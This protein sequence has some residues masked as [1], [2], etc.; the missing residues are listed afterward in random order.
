M[1]FKKMA[2]ATAAVSMLLV[3]ALPAHAAGAPVYVESLQ[4]AVYI[5]AILTSGDTF[6]SYTFPGVPDGS[7]AVLA[8]EN[9]RILTN[10][11]LSYSTTSAALQR[12]N[13]TAQGS[14]ISQIDYNLKTRSVSTVKEFLTSV[15]HY[16]YATKKFGKTPV[17]PAGATATDSYGTPLHSTFLARFC[18]SSLAPAGRL[19]YKLGKTTY[20]ITESVFLTGEETGDEGR[21]F[22]VNSKGQM[23]HI[24][25]FGLAAWET[26]NVVPTSSKVT[27][28]IGNE[29]N[30]ATNSQVSMYVGTKTTKGTWYEKAGFTNGARYILNFGGQATEAGFRSTYPKGQE[31]DVQFREVQ[32]EANGVDQNY[33]ASTVGT[34]LARVEDGSF[35]P[36]HPNDYYFITTESNKDVNATKVDPA[37]PLQPRDGGALWR[38]RFKDV[39]NPLAGAT[40]TMLLNG[41]EAP[42]LNKPD[43]LEVDAYGNILIQEDPG[44][45]PIRT[46]IFAYRISDG[47]IATLAQFKKEYFEPGQANFITQD[48]ETSGIF[49]ATKWL[50]KSATDTN[51]YYVFVAQV[52]ANVL[53]A[54]PDLVDQAAKDAA[55][56]AIEGGQMYIMTVKDWSSVYTG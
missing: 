7:G 29:D 32:T 19:A 22:V 43:N 56:K 42:Y 15:T 23:I 52:H 36:N 27:A 48:E 12:A 45:H 50:K 8:G 11:E 6:G 39:K 46:R 34:S 38:L 40:V 54:R 47:K 24:P 28:V 53:T 2:A 41:T 4:S 30:G 37:L 20:G 51:K 9:L 14:T 1:D 21:G 31:V 3:P 49:D 13:G 25:K 35:D 18:S 5:E 33:F 17:A 26:F 44:N 10:S 16:D 55:L